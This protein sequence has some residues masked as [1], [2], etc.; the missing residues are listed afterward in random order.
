MTRLPALS[1]PGW[2]IPRAPFA[3][4]A[5]LLAGLLA[6]T[7][8]GAL[9]VTRR[10]VRSYATSL[11][12]SREWTARRSLVFDLGALAAAAAPGADMLA[13]GD[14]PRARA[15]ER[16]AARRFAARLDTLRRAV[17]NELPDSA[18]EPL[19]GGFQDAATAMY[20]LDL[21]AGRLYTRL[22]RQDRAGAVQ[23][24]A[25]V[26]MAQLLM[27]AAVDRLRI[28][29][30][31]LEEDDFA[32]QA[33]AARRIETLEYV[34]AVALLMAAAAATWY[35]LRLVR[36]VLALQSERVSALEERFR[37]LAALAP[38]A[39][40]TL[41]PDGTYTFLNPA[42]ATITGW[43][44]TQWLGRN[45]T[46]LT[47]PDDLARAQDM[48]R[49]VLAAEAPPAFEL[50]VRM[51]T[52]EYRDA[53][54]TLTPDI[55]RGRIAGVLG[56]ARDM[57][58]RKRAEAALRESEQR[59]RAVVSGAPIVLLALNRDGIVT[60]S[61]GKALAALGR[62]PGDLVGRSVFEMYADVPPLRR[63]FQRALG[64]ESVNELV[65][66]G[67]VMLEAWIAPVR[68]AGGALAGAICVATDVTDRV[69]SEAARRHSEERFS[70]AFR[71]S[72]SPILITR[73]RDGLLVDA[74]DTFFAT[75]GFT[76]EEAIGRSTRDLLWPEPERRADMVRQMEAE[77]RVS[78]LELQ[79]RTK[80][81]AV[82][83]VLVSIESIELDGELHTIGEALDITDRKRAA[84]ALRES[85]ERFRRLVHD[86]GVGVVVLDPDFRV[87]LANPAA[88]EMWGVTESEVL[89]DG[90]RRL[91]FAYIREDGSEFPL[92]DRPERRA[93]ATRQPVHD[94][95]VGVRGPHRTEPSWILVDAEP[96]VDAGS[97]VRQLIVTLTNITDRRRSEV[98]QGQLRQA[99]MEAAADWTM[100]FDAVQTPI[101]IL[102]ADGRVRRLNAA[103]RD[104]AGRASYADAVGLTL[105]E[106]GSME[107]W[108][109]LAAMADDVRH[110]HASAETQV[111]T[112]HSHR[113]W[114]LIA[115]PVTVPGEED[116]V[117]VIARDVTDMVTLQD[118]LRR[119]ETMSALGS[120][121]AGVAHEVRNPLFAISATVDAFEARFGVN[122]AYE[123]YTGTLRQEV[124]RLSALMGEL[125]EYGKP[126]GLDLTVAPI[127]GAVRRAA[128]GCA[129]VA[130]KSDV[131]VRVDLP[132]AMP[133]VRLDA[134]R[135][136]QVFQNLILNAVQHSPRGGTVRVDGRV[137]A[138]REPAAVE[139]AVRDDGPGFRAE[140]LPHIYEPFFTRRRGGTGL[141][142]SIVQRIV[143]Q[144][145]GE[146]SAANRAEGGA[147]TVVRLTAFADAARR[148]EERTHVEA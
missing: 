28:S 7:L 22:E 71:A 101:L 139:I 138:E 89:G 75:T 3:R 72:P 124:N 129:A 48:V 112:D 135:M 29:M 27:N 76:R 128:A 90:M 118:S 66:R 60:L 88:L 140:D 9:F 67:P 47:H 17:A 55:E 131:T 146:V 104:L 40:F 33:R 102:G 56:I 79:M 21:A 83:D 59:L 58:S 136:Q 6:V 53:E 65:Q 108:H 19:L 126:P 31:R 93:R 109:S 63:M 64:G 16:D 77:G 115:S 147:V 114:Y 11:A 38:D 13:G 46:A 98:R 50:R 62:V 26:G 137:A 116:R 141:G 95:I 37:V 103:A 142:L 68:D 32:A 148:A 105:G 18:A 99:L 80:A 127:D 39:I 41:A 111:R 113:A 57:T 92:E 100:T 144:H 5:L 97:D 84:A 49:R 133:P 123:R 91:P 1:P 117:I 42:F 106:L 14:I 134:S 110:A 23:A 51:R 12:R 78:G 125:L 87:L 44:V 2:G 143:E 96:Q 86:L 52:G 36:R 122:A 121:V 25:N 119:T 45:F 4:V 30:R 8:L 85:E 61:E 54:F 120:L 34:I 73:L 81:G 69:R 130:E 132:P 10:L 145:G 43:P 24:L 20:E 70:K 107:P 74:N 94:V 35:G 82:L 15:R